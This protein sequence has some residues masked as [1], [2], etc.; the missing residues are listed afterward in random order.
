M[1]V[2][3]S[4]FLLYMPT[5]F[6]F[7]IF[8]QQNWKKPCFPKLLH[9]NLKTCVVHASMN[10]QSTFDNSES[11]NSYYIHAAWKTC[12]DSTNQILNCRQAIHH[13]TDPKQPSRWRILNSEVVLRN[14][15]YKIEFQYVCVKS[16]IFTWVVLF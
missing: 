12:L 15:K 10:E 3:L 7:H 9:K 1:S 5:I 13:W 8:M 16:Y 4:T 14:S 6:S 11:S 2:S